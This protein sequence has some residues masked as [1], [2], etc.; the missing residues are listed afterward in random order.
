MSM[1]RSRGLRVGVIAL[2]VVGLL[3]VLRPWT[4]EPIQTAVPAAFDAASYVASSWP[5]VLREADETAVDVTTVLRSSGAGSNDAG[6][7]PARTAQFVRGTGVVTEVNLQSRAGHALVR[8]DDGVAPATVAIQVGPVLRG[9][10]LR[11]ALS[12][13][14]FTDFVNQFD[15]A[16]VAN[17]LNNRALESV[18]GP[19]EVRAL[20]GER[21]SF[22]GAVA[23]DVRALKMPEIVPVRLTVVGRGGR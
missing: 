11:D 13:V 6:A 18:L 8:I 9:T 3:A 15:F 23:R 20:S 22:T 5:R 10:A 16:A 21:V 7:P 2:V 4:I 14:R 17:A 19:V 1:A 12:F